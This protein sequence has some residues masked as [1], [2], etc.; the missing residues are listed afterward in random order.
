MKVYVHTEYHHTSRSIVI[1]RLE[2]GDR[3]NPKWISL[4]GDRRKI[5]AFIILLGRKAELPEGRRG[6]FVTEV[7]DE[8]WR[9][10]KGI[11]E[12]NISWRAIVKEG[13]IQQPTLKKIREFLAIKKLID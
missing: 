1:E 7:S 3:E 4:H 10:L 5:L 2:G 11:S 9:I 12:L 13:I 8:E 6:D